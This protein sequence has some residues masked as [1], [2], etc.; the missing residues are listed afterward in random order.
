M[1]D[2]LGRKIEVS[3][4]ITYALRHGDYPSLGIY[5]VR[6]VKEN[7]IKAHKLNESY[8]DAARYSLMWPLANGMQVR[9]KYIVWDRGSPDRKP[10][11]RE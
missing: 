6:E 11:Y 7:S 1:K 8:R 3:Q 10:G 9:Q 5:H 4:Y 2:M